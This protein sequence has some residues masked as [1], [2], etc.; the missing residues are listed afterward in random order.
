MN[1]ELL[2]KKLEAAVDAAMQS[3]M[4]GKLEIEFVAGRATYIRESKQEKLVSEADNER[5]PRY[6]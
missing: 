5:L 4:Y 6:K 3:R 1:K 2:M